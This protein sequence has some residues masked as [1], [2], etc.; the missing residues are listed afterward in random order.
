MKKTGIL[1]LLNSF[2]LAL[3]DLI[4]DTNNISL[5]ELLNRTYSQKLKALIALNKLK[6]AKLITE[7]DR[8]YNSLL[9]F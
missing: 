9:Y 8:T 4:G 7:K 6:Y 1:S 3:L 5:E 2:E